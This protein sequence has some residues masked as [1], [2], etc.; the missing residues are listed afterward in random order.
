MLHAADTAVPGIT[1]DL[2]FDLDTPVPVRVAARLAGVDSR[3]IHR[4]VSKGAVPA[5][6]TPGG[7]LRVV[8]RDCL[9]APR[10]QDP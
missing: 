2:D 5:Y 1:A 8:P 7:S 10:P 6:E 4:W 9:P 3:T